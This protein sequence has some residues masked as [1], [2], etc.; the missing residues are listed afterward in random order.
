MQERHR[1]RKRYFDEQGITTLKHVIPFI[2]QVKAV[3]SQTSVLEI[4]C[5]EGGNLTPFVDM[6]CMSA[7]IDISKTRI[8]AAEDFFSEHPNRSKL[9]LVAEDIY[10]V[11]AEEIR[12]YD[13]IMMRDVIEHIP[14]Q[15]KFM[16]YVKGFLAQDGMFFLGFPPWYN[17]FG[18]HQ[19]ICKSKLLSKLPWFH[20]LPRPL[21]RGVL[22][23]FGEPPHT[24][25]DLTDIHD[26][27]ISIER[28][29]RILRKHGYKVHREV[30]WFINPNYETKFKL[31]PRKLWGIIGMLPWVR[32]FYCT[33]A[34]YLISK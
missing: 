19:Q 20:L 2:G 13:V 32:N 6:G 25:Q 11:K 22:K 18:G 4:G 29:R 15:D 23:L 27:G 9:H 26:T 24:F 34:Y 33:C 12:P 30:F 14:D 5:G 16:G 1:N 17:P 21:Y 10:Q 3:S 28:F 8:E 7:G 31:K